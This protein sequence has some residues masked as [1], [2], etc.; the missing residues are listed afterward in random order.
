MI[1]QPDKTIQ[2]S[3]FSIE[4]DE[5]IP[6]R[7]QVNFYIRSRIKDLMDEKNL[8]IAD[9]SRISGLRY[10]TVRDYYFDIVTKK[11][12]DVLAVFCATL[13]CEPSDLDELVFYDQ[14]IS[15][16]EKV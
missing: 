4:Y 2:E 16:L 9:V 5:L 13:R 1:K 10:E 12:R 6:I 8:T 15:E 3:I 11:D 14:K 7:E